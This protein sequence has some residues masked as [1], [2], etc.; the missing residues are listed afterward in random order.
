MTEFDATSGPAPRSDAERA[1]AF[2]ELMRLE[3]EQNKAPVSGLAVAGL[4]F[5]LAF[6]ALMFFWVFALVVGVSALV[7]TVFALPQIMH[8]DR[9]GLA[10]V[11]VDLVVV[12]AGVWIMLTMLDR[13]FPG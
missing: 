3:R 8:G 11:I 12:A 1:A 5:G 4:G 2:D 13:I 6:V 9:R 7:F 10:I